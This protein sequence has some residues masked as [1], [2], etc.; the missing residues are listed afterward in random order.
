MTRLGVQ[1]NRGTHLERHGRAPKREAGWTGQ[2]G[3]LP[4]I[5]ATAGWA[6]EGRRDKDLT[7]P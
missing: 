6:G 2:R 5:L 1:T 7:G 4:D 3:I